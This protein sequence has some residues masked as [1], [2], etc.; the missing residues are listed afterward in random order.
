MGW[1]QNACALSSWFK[2]Y[3]FT[4]LRQHFFVQSWRETFFF[5]PLKINFNQGDAIKSLL[6]ATLILIPP[7]QR[8]FG[9][10]VMIFRAVTTTAKQIREV[11]LQLLGASLHV[12]KW[13]WLEW[14]QQK[15][16]DFWDNSYSLDQD[17]FK[18]EAMASTEPMA[19]FVKQ[20]GKKKSFEN[21]GFLWGLYVKR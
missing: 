18:V 5:S 21:S 10:S 12:L 20:P 8:L 15:D 6:Y 9:Q 19:C 17:R 7:Q 13:Q 14:K 4:N 2:C 3:Y 11:Q 1:L 16:W